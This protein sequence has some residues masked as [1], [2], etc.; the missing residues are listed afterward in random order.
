MGNTL[1]IDRW[2][3]DD[4]LDRLGTAARDARIEAERASR[5]FPPFR[6]PHEGIAILEEEFLELRSAV[7]W[8]PSEER[9][10]AMRKEA[11]QTAAMALRFVSDC[12][13]QDTYE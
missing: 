4:E 12:C 11:I 10:E 13:L 7:F 8:A 6:S 2:L 9:D 5:R 3:S 1:Q